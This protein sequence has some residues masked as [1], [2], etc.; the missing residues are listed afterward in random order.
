MGS[1]HQ[2]HLGNLEYPHCSDNAF[3]SPSFSFVHK[4][5]RNDTSTKYTR[6]ACLSLQRMKLFMICW[7]IHWGRVVRGLPRVL[8][9]RFNVVFTIWRQT[10]SG[11]REDRPRRGRWVEREQTWARRKDSEPV[12]S[13][14]AGPGDGGIPVLSFL[15]KN[16]IW[17]SLSLSPNTCLK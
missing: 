12:R 2:I 10:R 1:S 4:K 13:R 5:L 16:V 7:V 14:G 17:Q 11:R 3:M 15:E 9:Q 8:V 6:S